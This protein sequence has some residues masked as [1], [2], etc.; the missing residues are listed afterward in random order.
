M[1]QRILLKNKHHD[2]KKQALNTLPVLPAWAGV[3]ADTNHYTCSFCKRLWYI[4]PGNLG[5]GATEKGLARSVTRTREK[6][7]VNN[8]QNTPAWRRIL[9]V[10]TF[11][12]QKLTANLQGNGDKD[13]DTFE[14]AA[15]MKQVNDLVISHVLRKFFFCNTRQRFTNWFKMGLESLKNSLSAIHE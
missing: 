14:F 12:W 11:I 6:N 1:V 10:R 7:A 13:V 8:I 9:P 2:A 4:S 3:S 5:W 15:W